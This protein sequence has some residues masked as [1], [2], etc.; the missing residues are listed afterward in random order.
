MNVKVIHEKTV[1][2]GPVFDID[3]GDRAQET[4]IALGILE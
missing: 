3:R 4:E 2:I 1:S